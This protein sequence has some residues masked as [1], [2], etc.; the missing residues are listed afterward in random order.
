VLWYQHQTLTPFFTYEK[1]NLMP[2]F[3]AA[4]VHRYRNYVASLLKWLKLPTLV[5]TVAASW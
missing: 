3:N 4:Q 2:L 5:S 1:M